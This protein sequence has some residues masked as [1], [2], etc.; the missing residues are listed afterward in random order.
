MHIGLWSEP[1]GYSAPTGCRPGSLQHLGIRH[2]YNIDP[3][4]MRRGPTWTECPHTQASSMLAC[5]FFLVDTVLLR[6]LYLVFFIELDTRRVYVTGVAAHPIGSW[7][8]QQTR[9]LTMT[10][11]DRTHSS[12]SSFVTE[13]PSSPQASTRS[14]R[15]MAF[16]SSAPR[17]GHPAPT[18][19]PSVSS[20]PSVANASTGC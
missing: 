6:R 7:V 16:A 17:R 14:S 2:R 15:P 10:L 3:S 19:S 18:P 8:V 13:T 5:D 12:G 4:P 20:A 11:V 9:N 1:D